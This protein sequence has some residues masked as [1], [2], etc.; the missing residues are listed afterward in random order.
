MP[1][2]GISRLVSAT[3]QAGFITHFY[4][5]EIGQL[6]KYTKFCTLIYVMLRVK[7]RS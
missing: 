5:V 7:S 1:W 3:R 4:S 6:S 2:L